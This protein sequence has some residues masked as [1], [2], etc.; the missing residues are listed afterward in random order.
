MKPTILY[1]DDEIM[2]LNLFKEIFRDE[3]EVETASTLFEARQLLSNHSPDVIISDWSMP[4]ISGVEF[5]SEA[6]R[7]CPN[8][9]RI[10]LTGFADAGEM[11]DEIRSGVIQLFI[12]KPWSEAEMH[13]ALERALLLRS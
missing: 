8:A 2:L 12:P 5:L 9:F 1:L 7:V 3:Y 11:I 13:E 6:A 4:E 10:L